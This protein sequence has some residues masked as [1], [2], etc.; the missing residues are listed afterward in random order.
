[1]SSQKKP[2]KR[3]EPKKRESKEEEKSHNKLGFI[4]EK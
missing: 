1:V 2:L 4:E 3:E